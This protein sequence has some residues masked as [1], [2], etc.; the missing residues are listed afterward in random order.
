MKGDSNM[1]NRMAQQDAC[2]DFLK[3]LVYYQPWRYLQSH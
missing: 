1:L 3:G 2:S